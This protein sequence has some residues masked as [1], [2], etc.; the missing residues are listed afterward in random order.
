MFMLR[1]WLDKGIIDTITNLKNSGLNES[2]IKTMLKDIG[3][4]DSMI[5]EFFKLYE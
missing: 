3:F 1:C 2:E 4:E 5:D